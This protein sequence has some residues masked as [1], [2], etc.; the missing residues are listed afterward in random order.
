MKFYH[1][2]GYEIQHLR[3]SNGFTQSQLGLPHGAVSLFEKGKRLPSEDQIEAMCKAMGMS[4]QTERL[5]VL[6]S[7]SIL[8]CRAGE[9]HVHYA[10]FLDA[11]IN[12]VR[13]NGSDDGFWRRMA[14]AIENA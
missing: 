9:V 4:G 12:R 7:L 2:F 8:R 1:A 13:V 5:K 10:S 14:A 3:V 11:L 6:R